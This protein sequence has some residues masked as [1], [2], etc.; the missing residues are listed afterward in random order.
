MCLKATQNF[1]NSIALIISILYCIIY[2]QNQKIKNTKLVP[3]EK[4]IKNKNPY[5]YK[6]TAKLILLALIQVGIINIFISLKFPK[7]YLN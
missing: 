5:V 4:F 7:Q 2:L 3:L 6:Q 1:Q